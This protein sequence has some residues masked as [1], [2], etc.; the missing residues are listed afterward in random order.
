[1]GRHTY[2]MADD[3]DTYVGN[4]EFQVPIFV[5]TKH[6]PKR[7][8][9][10]SDQLTFTFVT[11]G[12]DAIAQAKAA[13]GDKDVTV[14]GGPSVIQQCVRLS[15]PMNSTLTSCPCCWAAGCACLNTSATN[16]SSWRRSRSWRRRS[17]PVCSSA[18]SSRETTPYRVVNN[19]EL[20]GNSSS[21]QF[22]GA[23][24]GAANVSFFLSATPPGHDQLCTS[25]L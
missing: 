10:Q 14:V 1:M 22:E 6:A 19:Q 18:L 24:H 16:L 17:E 3:P 13:G 20:P 2:A 21:Y 9:K 25:T 5:L 11:D 8:P 23:L 7:L 15:W 12:I 4:Y